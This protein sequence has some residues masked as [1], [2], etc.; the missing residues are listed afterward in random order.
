MSFPLVLGVLEDEASQKISIFN[1][2]MKTSFGK[3]HLCKELSWVHERGVE[4][5]QRGRAY[6]GRCVSGC[7]ERKRY[8]QI[9]H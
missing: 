4:N 3:R 9:A 6:G 2:I 8:L 1:P 7:A 5:Q